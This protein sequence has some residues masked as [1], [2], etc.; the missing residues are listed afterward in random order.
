MND[1]VQ[2]DNIRVESV[3]LLM[4]GAIRVLCTSSSLLG[5]EEEES[6]TRGSKTA[7]R[8]FRFFSPEDRLWPSEDIG[9]NQA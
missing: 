4:N 3:F 7:L 2:S 1:R 8:P 9:K 6:V 5:P